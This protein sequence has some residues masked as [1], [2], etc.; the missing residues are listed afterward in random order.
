MAITLFYL[1]GRTIC[2]RMQQDWTASVSSFVSFQTHALHANCLTTTCQ[3]VCRAAGN[4]CTTI[5]NNP[6]GEKWCD[7]KTKRQLETN[8]PKRIERN[9]GD[10]RTEDEKADG[11]ANK[12][13]RDS[14][15]QA[16]R[17]T[18]SI[19]RQV[20]K[21]NKNEDAEGRTRDGMQET[22][23]R[24]WKRHHG[25]RN[26]S[27]QPRVKLVLWWHVGKAW[28]LDTST[29]NDFAR[30]R[31]Q[32]LRRPWRLFGLHRPVDYR[33]KPGQKINAGLQ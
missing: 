18:G 7:E 20:M 25:A 29:D 30:I 12:R 33:L 22:E 1:I 4:V 23:D 9:A 5:G 14:K 11:N 19:E 13:Q 31:K 2:R 10:E 6:R 27:S 3:C 17:R 32:R 16:K 15:R 24:N 8:T 21:R 26:T 28:L